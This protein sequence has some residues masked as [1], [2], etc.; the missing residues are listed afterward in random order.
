MLKFCFSTVCMRETQLH[1]L[2][3][4]DNWKKKILDQSNLRILHSIIYPLERKDWIEQLAL[5]TTVT[6]RKRRAAGLPHLSRFSITTI[7]RN[8]RRPPISVG[9]CSTVLIRWT[10]PGKNAWYHTKYKTCSLHLRVTQPLRRRHLPQ[11]IASA[12]LSEVRLIS[13]FHKNK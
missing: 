5:I 1:D 13:T 4:S 3:M 11:T 10:T 9:S 2:S 12:C 8:P 6:W 7:S